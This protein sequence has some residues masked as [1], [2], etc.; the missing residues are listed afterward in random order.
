MENLAR[1]LSENI[2]F[3]SVVNFISIIGFILTIWVACS[4]RTIKSY[5][6]FRIRVPEHIKRLKKLASEISTLKARF[7]ESIEDI[8]LKMASV[9]VEIGALERKTRTNKGVR[10]SLRDLQ[11]LI[12]DY[13]STSPRNKEKLS[14]TYIE[15]HKV[16][17]EIE[18]L[19]ADLMWEK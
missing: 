13:R 8:D 2:Y 9:E 18:N 7:D 4:L 17:R 12:Q 1:L 11:V 6:V 5:Y 16:I 15:L 19:Q 3:V 10:S 14:K